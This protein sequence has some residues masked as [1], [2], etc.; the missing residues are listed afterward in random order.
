MPPPQGKKDKKAAR[1][2]SVTDI[3][4]EEDKLAAIETNV[5]TP[6]EHTTAFADAAAE[7][8]ATNNE[9]DEMYRGVPAPG[10][11]AQWREAYAKAHLNPNE[12]TPGP[13]LDT[14]AA[15]Y[16]EQKK[17][18]EREK[19]KDAQTVVMAPSINAITPEKPPQQTHDNDERV[20]YVIH[21]ETFFRQK[22]ET[23][24]ECLNF[25]ETTKRFN[26]DTADK[27]MVSHFASDEAMTQYIDA[28]MMLQGNK[29]VNEQGNS[30]IKTVPDAS[31]RNAGSFP[32]PR[33]PLINPMAA[34]V[35][36]KRSATVIPMA[37]GMSS[38]QKTGPTVPESGGLTKKP[39]FGFA[40]ANNNM[41]SSDANM[42]KFE[43]TLLG[44]AMKIESW[45]IL[46][47]GCPFDAWGFTLKFN[48]E[49]YW[50]WKPSVLEKAIQAEQSS[51][52]FEKENTTMDT[53]LFNVRAANIRETPCGPNNPSAFVLKSG[54]KMDHMTLFALIPSP[55]N[56]EIIRQTIV[57]FCAQCKDPR[58]QMAYSKTFDS[59]FKAE[60]IK[61]DARP[62]GLLWEKLAGASHNIVY[63]KLDMLSQV[64][65]DHTI[66][67]IIRL[68]YELPGG[69]SPS[70][71]DKKLFTL[72]Y[73]EKMDG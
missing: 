54:K 29:S 31:A 35:S 68:S 15:C 57:Q 12:V 44:S 28:L 72:A 33:L 56:E 13:L 67:E 21:K 39:K 53:M 19:N 73:G 52:L 71:W 14:Y 41:S 49:H 46:L 16:E 70:M 62:G 36:T 64:L 17:I 10:L 26:P 63:H 6:E 65:C 20:Y 47:D 24:Q 2:S 1:K 27:L 55:S 5:E 38:N 22:F 30:N 66:E 48:N 61:K 45:H 9:Q 32:M 7:F 18:E 25:F 51:P 3:S 11:S 59:I 60:N 23:K 8:S 37:F 40:S 69:L 43:E 42:K 4:V 34:A 58:V 50:S